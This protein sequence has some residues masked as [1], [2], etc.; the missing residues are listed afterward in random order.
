MI[1]PLI[2]LIA[3]SSVAASSLLHAADPL[4]RV[5][6]GK[7]YPI[8]VETPKKFLNPWPEAEQERFM[9]KAAELIEHFG[10]QS[11]RGS[12]VNE[13]EKD[14]YPRA[15]FHILAGKEEEGAHALMQSQQY[16]P[17]PFHAFTGGF[18]FWFGFTLKGQARKYFHFGEYLD[19]DY[20]RR[21]EN[22]F[23]S[24]TETDPRTTPHPHYKKYDPKKQGWTPE[25]FGNRQVDGR[26]TDNLYAMTT[27]TTYLFAEAAG[28]EEVRQKSWERIRE[29]G[30]TA[31]M[32]GIGE[33]DS[34]NYLGHTMSAYLNLY[35]FAEDPKVKMHAKG[36]LD[37]ISTAMAVK[38]WRGGW[39][40]AVKRD[41]GNIMA[42]RGLALQ[43]GHLYYDDLG[44]EEEGN[45]DDVYHITSA[46]RP[47]MAAVQLARGEFD[48]PAELLISHPVYENW[49]TDDA[50]RSGRDFPDFHETL[51]FGHTYRFGSL[52]GGNGGDVSG[53]SV[54]TENSQRGTDYL[55]IGHKLSG[56]RK[57][58]EKGQTLDRSNFV[59]TDDG[60]TNVAQYRNL[61]LYLTDAGDADFYL[62]TAHDAIQPLKN[63]IQ[64]LKHE[65]TWIALTPIGL[66]WKGRD[67]TLSKGFAPAGDML[68]GKGT[69]GDYAG[70]AI[71]IGEP[72]THGD[73]DTFVENVLSRA[74]VKTEGEG[75]WTYAGSQGQSVGLKH[76]GKLPG[77]F[78][79]KKDQP[80]VLERVRTPE[81]VYEQF[82]TVIRN[83]EPHE[84]T[85]HFAQYR[86][87]ENP[88][89]GPVSLGFKEG[90]LRVRTRDWTF[91]G[92]M[93]PDGTYTFENHRR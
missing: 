33:W 41:Y 7:R 1:R 34:E 71:E 12:T 79:N 83:G 52:V 87:P 22:A 11:N 55:K 81:E 43:T 88:D 2:S 51:F 13:R 62:I 21:F 40:G 73:F 27:V 14:L 42:L 63:G 15:M 76:G 45:R 8:P 46:Y 3:L 10:A 19:D 86:N 59:T 48:K 67:E 36:I 5:E 93:K 29:Y 16:D 39:G 32:N 68:V 89:A 65:K 25:R 92:V 69:G 58:I 18:D 26:R 9:E 28:N 74:E 85:D 31:Y 37:W 20:R 57:K 30:V 35:D 80:W 61:A 49:K 47:P 54:I 50:G 17:K 75:A 91:K 77:L 60:N 4:V 84:W 24:W 53:F 6:D 66:E 64:F 23:D 44:L 70:F 56:P 38:Y 90:D 82:P 78:V 72:Q